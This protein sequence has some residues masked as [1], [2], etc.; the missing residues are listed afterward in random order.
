MI[1]FTRIL[2]RILCIGKKEK[3]LGGGG[4]LQKTKKLLYSH[5]VIYRGAIVTGKYFYRY[6]VLQEHFDIQNW[7]NTMSVG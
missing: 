3:K 7:E 6:F 5:V 2:V 1:Y 4:V